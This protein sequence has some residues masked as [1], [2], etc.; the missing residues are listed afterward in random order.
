MRLDPQNVFQ[1]TGSNQQTRGCDKARDHRVAQEIRQKAQTEYAH[2]KQDQPRQEG[3]RDGR[4]DIVGLAG[5]VEVSNGGRRHQADNRN[6]PDG[7]R[8]RRTENR[9]G[10]QGQDRR[11]KTHFGGK[12]GQQRI[13]QGLRDQHDRDDHR[14]QQVGRKRPLIVAAPPVQQWHELS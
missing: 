5:Q 7:Q 9:I 1:L 4:S 6:R 2:H 11:V 8:T 12:T 13:G 10:D 3:Q 14:R